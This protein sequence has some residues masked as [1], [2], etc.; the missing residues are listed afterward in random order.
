MKSQKPLFIALAYGFAAG[1]IAALVLALMLSVQHWLWSGSHADSPA[2][3][4]AIILLGG[5]LLALLQHLRHGG[6]ASDGDLDGQLAALHAPVAC[7]RRDTL[8]LAL[9]AI[10]A[11][12]FGGAI[13]P[14]AGL[15]AVV[16]E[17][18]AIV[19]LA[20]AR[21]QSEQRLINDTG[22]VAALSGLYGAPPG[23]AVLV[24]ENSRGH[25]DAEET[26]LALKLLAGVSGF[27]GFLLLGNWLLP[28]DFQQLPLPDY[29]ALE[30]RHELLHALL[31]ALAGALLGVLFVHLHRQMP[32]LF[33]KITRHPTRQIL[34][35][36]LLFAALAAAFPL[37]RF[38]GH[39]ELEHA[40]AH[41]VHAGVWGLLALAVGK[42]LA[43]AICL[44]GG[45]RGGEFFPALFAAAA[46]A[47][48][49]QSLLPELPLTL[50]ILAAG[51]AIATVCMGKPA[52]VL[53]IM[54]LIAGHAAPVALFVGIAIGH[55]VRQLCVGTRAGH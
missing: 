7:K 32:K 11:V 19:A 36:S 16:A 34:L 43:M 20:L 35:A 30:A 40:L 27:A 8:L 41:G 12:G 22:A 2:Y 1:A 9:S 18:S 42:L 3:I 31:P 6:A 14:E 54:L 10:V 38:S 24:D 55:V 47:A 33:D 51:S 23:A 39:H 44:A 48:A 52:A 53:L 25:H 4:F 15:L 21:S 46:L 49:M 26:P 13:G 28:G 37:L 45:W 29:A 5:G 50:A 17:C